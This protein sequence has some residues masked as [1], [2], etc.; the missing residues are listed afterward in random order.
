MPFVLMTAFNR[1]R[2]SMVT[3]DWRFDTAFDSCFPM[4]K[5]RLMAVA[6]PHSS[7][8]TS[9]HVHAS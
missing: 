8:T 1:S 5:A 4:L 9:V 2:V 3:L 6:L 7:H